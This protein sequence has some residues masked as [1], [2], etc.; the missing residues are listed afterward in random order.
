V[1]K[2][3]IIFIPSRSN[4]NG[5]NKTI[6]LLYSSCA[7]VKNFDIVCIV[8]DDE[9]GLYE[10]V[11]NRFPNVIWEHPPHAGPNSKHINKIIFET[12]QNKDYHLNWH[13]VDDMESLSS[14]WDKNMLKTKGIYSDGF[15]SCFSSNPMSRNLN[16]MSSC[17]RAP[18]LK[19][20]RGYDSPL[21]ED[22]VE[23]IYHYHEM[24]PVCTKKWRMALRKFYDE[25]FRGPDIV[26]LNASLA[27]ILSKQFGYSRHLMIDFEYLVGPDS[28]RASKVLFQGLNRDQFYYKYA[29]EENFQLIRSVAEV[30]SKEIW[31]HY[32]D[33]MDKPRGIGKYTP[34]KQNK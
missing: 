13:I 6:E 10:S 27:H 1:S 29:R 12:V 33:I 9:I 32:R 16:A 22:S 34:Q 24:L 14:N 30:V 25:D 17:F 7:S 20:V 23:L 5:C 21:V 31:Q 18:S 15:Y 28:H 26:F 3:I 4:P 11:I 2:D 8:D 19:W